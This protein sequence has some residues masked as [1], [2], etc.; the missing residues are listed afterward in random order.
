M[1]QSINNF[2][3]WLL[4]FTA[5]LGAVAFGLW[6]IMPAGY[7]SPVL[8]LLFPF[9][10]AVTLIVFYFLAKS[11][12]KKFSSFINRFMLATFFKLTVYMAVLLAYVFT[13]K[14]DAVNFI[15]SF[16]ILY[17]AYTAFEVVE[18]MRYSKRRKN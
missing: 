14:E 8:P 10:F 5:L 13:H 2:S 18:M 11:A 3:L 1:N 6:F 7:F 17:V 12:E 15:I 9:F 4:L 16:F